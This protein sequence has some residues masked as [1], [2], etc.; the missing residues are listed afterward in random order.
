MKK[1]KVFMVVGTLALAITAIFASRANKKFALTIT[2]ARAATSGFYVVGTKAVFTA[3]SQG[4]THYLYMSL[5]TY[6]GH[7]FS[8]GTS[9]VQLFTKTAGN[10]NPVWE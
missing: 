2:T 9:A 4:A 6:N 1:S 8:A 3:T 5:Y 7:A 10:T